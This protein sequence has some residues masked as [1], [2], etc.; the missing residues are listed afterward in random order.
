MTSQR[1]PHIGPPVWEWCVRTKDDADPAQAQ[2]RGARL[3]TAAVVV[4]VALFAL[5]GIGGPL[6]GHGVFAATDALVQSSPYRDAGLAGTVQTAFQN[7]TYDTFLPNTLLFA[8]ALKAGHIAAWNPYILGGVPL[9]ATPNFAVASPLTL[10]YYLLPGWLAPAWTKLLEIA[11]SVGGCFL[12]GR[13]AGLGRPAALVGGL[14]FATSAFLIA[15]TGW[16]QTRTAALIGFV[17]WAVERLVQRGRALDAVLLAAS[18]AAMLFGGFPAVTG[19]TLFFA[20]I[21]LV[22]RVVAEHRSGRWGADVRVLVGAAAGLAGGVALAAVQLLP[23]GS[24]MSQALVAGREQTP[25]DHLPPEALITALA[26]EGLGNVNPGQQPAFMLGVNF[27][28]A[29]SYVGAVA[30]VLAVV[31]VASPGR[32][33]GLLPRGVWFFLIVAIGLTVATTYGGG[34]LLAVAQKLPVLFS[35]NYVGRVR[36]V[37]GFL[38]AVLAAAGFEVVLRGREPTREPTGRL[39]WAVPVYGAVVWLAAAAGTAWIWWRARDL[40]RATDTAA[41]DDVARLYLL[42][43]QVLAALVL[44]AVAVAGVAVLRWVGGGRVLRGLRVGVAVLLPMLI[45]VQALGLVRDY[46][47]RSERD[48]FYPVTDAQLYLQQNLG[49]ERYAFALDGMGTGADI[50]LGLRALNGHIFVNGTMSD[51]IEALPG[52]QFQDPPTLPVFSAGPGVAT[53]PV[54][55]RLGVRY[56]VTSPIQ[57][58]FGDLDADV[59]DGGTTRLAPETPISV[60]IPPGAALR[61]LAV[62]PE[63]VPDVP[64]STRIEVV[65]RAADGSVVA[66]NSRIDAGMVPGQMFAVPLTEAPGPAVTA[67]VTVHGPQPI[68]VRT[69]AGAPAVSTIRAQDDGL[70]LTHAGSS[71]IYQRL[72][73]L[74]RIRW[75][76]ETV[77]EPDPQ[78]QVQLVASGTLR[79]DQVVL[80]T[81]GPAATAGPATLDVTDDGLDDIDVTVDAAGSGYLVVADAL[82][83]GW[84]VEVDGQPAA[85]RPADH[86]TVAVAVPAGHHVVHW[87]YRS[88]TATAG[89]WVSTVAALGLLA[90]VGL[91]VWR[92]RR[93]SAMTT[94]DTLSPR[95]EADLESVGLG[96]PERTRR[97]HDHS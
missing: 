13:R 64:G 26:P 57:P 9:G 39:R 38:I 4:A 60:P 46:W 70:Q 73:A 44:V 42:D 59:G 31:A 33:R 65:L 45:A 68:T 75:A 87:Q 43:R 48:T 97:G 14:V 58:V 8:D 5:I 92:R 12:F 15:W 18:V 27:V 2:G 74:P 67:E 84:T 96:S 95:G 34:P 93:D 40:A 22:V 89:V 83:V 51:L 76:S 23:F 20:A 61:G 53:S 79:P 62:I 35:D 54:L 25:Q 82:Q 50:P 56:F 29:L 30:I 11:V 77:V 55:D 24:F 16:P 28:E 17:F 10:P 41:A 88:A 71:V 86:G 36:S 81:P 63:S 78:R 19:Y 69:T 49:H 47:P 1:R 37:L 90:I 52:A 66:R 32:G 6:I 80:G 91:T 7:D 3:V 85:V 72:T 94:L 21:Y